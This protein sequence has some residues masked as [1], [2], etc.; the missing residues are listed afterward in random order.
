MAARTDSAT[1][2]LNAGFTQLDL[3][4]SRRYRRPIYLADAVMLVLELAVLVL[5]A[6]GPLGDAL[7]DPLENLAWWAAAIA[8]SALVIAFLAAVAVPAGLWRWQRERQF[9]LSDQRLTGWLVDRTK[10]LTVELVLGTAALGGLVSLAHALP[11]AWPL[12][13]A[14]VAAGLVVLLSF[15]APVVLEPIFNRFEPLADEEL[16]GD[17]R[18]L[19]NRAGVPVQNVL[20]VDASRQTLKQNA[21][22]SGLGRTRRVV[23]FDTL[24]NGAD[25]R[26]VKLVVAHELGHRR[27]GHVVRLTVGAAIAAAGAIIALWGLL[28]LDALLDAVGASSAGDPRI[29]PFVLLAGLVLQLVLLPPTTAL[30]RRYERAADRASLELTGDLDTFERTH[31]SL[32]R[33]NVS[34]LDPPRALYLAT[35]T[36][37]TPP[38]RIAA[39]RSWARA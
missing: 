32:A 24:L 7:F 27:D 20:V 2:V 35:F 1:A 9:G 8:Y 26:E 21:Y 37:P 10:G 14:P 31:V 25:E 4:R 13:A 16:A 29:L 18:E 28:H 36:H 6:F 23:V 5:M 22:V 19:A 15:V 11:R 38:E 12:V 3:D 17:L 30:S 39:A 34:D 33:A